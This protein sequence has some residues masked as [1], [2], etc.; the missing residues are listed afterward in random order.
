MRPIRLNGRKGVLWG[1]IVLL[2]WAPLPLGSNRP[3]AWTVLALA[4]GLLL[5]A[6]T[7]VAARRPADPLLSWRRIWPAIAGLVLVCVT[8][9]LQL[10]PFTPDGWHHPMWI[11]ARAALGDAAI[12]RVSLAPHATATGLMRLLTYAGVFWLAMQLSRTPGGAR[13]LVRALVIIG[14][15]YAVY[16]L[17]AHMLWPDMIL[18]WRKWHSTPGLTSTF[19]CRGC[20]AAYAGLGLLCAAG[21]AMVSVRQDLSTG[22]RRLRPGSWLWIGSTLVLAIALALTQSRTGVVASGI[23]LASL[24]LL[25]DMDRSTPGRYAM[26]AALVVTVAAGAVLFAGG[27][28]LDRIANTQIEREVRFTTVY[29]AVMTAIGDAPWLGVG[30]GA[31]GE[32]VEVY[33]GQI[34]QLL[35]KAHNTYLETALELGIAGSLLFAGVIATLA[36]L[37]LHKLARRRNGLYAALGVAA[38]VLVAT[39]SL[40]DF[41]AELAAVA[42][43]YCAILGVGVGRAHRITPP[44]AKPMRDRRS[45]WDRRA[46][47]ALAATLGVLLIGFGVPRLVAQGGEMVMSRALV[48]AQGPSE[49]DRALALGVAAADW[50]GDPDM[51]VRLAMLVSRHA[52]PRDLPPVIRRARLTLARQMAHDAAQSAPSNAMAWLVLAQVDERLESGSAVAD[53]ALALSILGRPNGPLVCPR[54]LVALQ[55]WRQLDERTKRLASTQFRACMQSRPMAL[56][57]AVRRWGQVEAVWEAL[58]DAPRLQQRFDRMVQLIGRPQGP[59][60]Q[61]ASRPEREGHLPPSPGPE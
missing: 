20:Y 12:G 34:P 60:G 1:L 21:L 41:G 26:A 35:A 8:I 36:W 22:G 30:Y 56:G 5:L 45:R 3:L 13:L 40:T 44:Y 48:H 28:T 23:G 10:V 61:R 27:E 31:F 57:K 7:V 46:G 47:L 58:G 25:L 49:V 17:L 14:V 37:C 11:E 52:R 39:D 59:G 55:T 19:V 43:T 6:W 54:V 2:A 50:T 42:V 9:V 29:P 53:A 15:A 24:I 38:T 18:W 51:R 16:G 4:T 33:K 32:A